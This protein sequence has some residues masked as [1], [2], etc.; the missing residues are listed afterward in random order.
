MHRLKLFKTPLMYISRSAFYCVTGLILFFTVLLSACS[1]KKIII[2]SDI[3]Y[4]QVDP[5]SLHDY[6]SVQL[7]DKKYQDPNLAIGVSISGGG[8]RAQYFGLGVL[9]GIEEIK[10]KQNRTM[11]SGVD[12][13][14]TASG[15]GYAVG[16]YLTMQKNFLLR[17]DSPYSSFYQYW[18]SDDRVKKYQEFIWQ[19]AKP[20]DAIF[21]FNKN[22]KDNVSFPYAERL[23]VQL[24]Q[25]ER[26]N[27]R[28]VLGDFFV[29]VNESTLPILPMFVANGTIYKN[30]ERLPFMPHILNALRVDR[31]IAPSDS[32][33]RKN[34][35][36]N[37][38]LC[39]AIAGSSAFPGLLPQLRLGISADQNKA[40]RVVDGGVVDNLG[41]RTLIELLAEDNVEAI[42]K[43]AII[44]D[45]AGVG[46]VDRY[47][48][49]QRISVFNVLEN[50]LL[51]TVDSKYMTRVEDIENKLRPTGIPLS[52][53]VLLSMRT[54]LAKVNRTDAEVQQILAGWRK[55][56]GKKESAKESDERWLKNY[57]DFEASVKSHC[58]IT[59]GYVVDDVTWN[60]NLLRSIDLISF[61][62]M[63]HF[64]NADRLM[65]YEL[66]SQIE[67]KVKIHRSEKII[68]TLAGRYAAYLEQQ[69][70]NQLVTK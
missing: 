11:L 48:E 63:K 37:F 12:Y 60:G 30:V 43:R 61:D 25:R 46:E 29:P 55:I 47:S 14:S 53:Y 44:V 5:V 23:D 33:F 4:K 24:L 40:I 65:L 57:R 39:Y 8:S 26:T 27:S 28:M 31:I 6:K 49:D 58:A 35:A 70:L 2:N 59:P 19:S 62:E 16:Y 34:P 54:I 22:E 50:A 66:V 3:V 68:L 21:R 10:D 45:C 32:S 20:S 41:Y 38:P 64:T 7:R 56:A 13:F 15:G 18:L 17:A 1:S 42:N 67:T 36:Y 69:K 52:N 51:F 9:M